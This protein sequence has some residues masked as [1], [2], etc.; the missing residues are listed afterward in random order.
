VADADENAT[1]NIKVRDQLFP[2]DKK[3][4]FLKLNR[5]GFFWSSEGVFNK[6]ME[7][8]TVPSTTEKE[9]KNSES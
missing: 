3:F 7:E 2:L 4:R 9:I 1:Q 5:E 8:I 6:N